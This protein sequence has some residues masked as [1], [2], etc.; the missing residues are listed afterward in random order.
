MEVE[1]E[2]EMRG[3]MGVAAAGGDGGAAA[4]DGVWYGGGRGSEAGLGDLRCWNV[5]LWAEGMVLEEG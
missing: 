4:T 3:M 1:V 5:C 2:V